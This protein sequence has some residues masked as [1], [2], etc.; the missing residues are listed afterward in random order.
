MFNFY[1]VKQGS[2]DSWFWNG[3]SKC[4]SKYQLATYL[5]VI[6]VSR[7]YQF[8]N[9]EGDVS[10]TPYYDK[11]YECEKHYASKYRTIDGSCNNIHRPYWG[12]SNTCHIRLLPPDYSDGIQAFRMAKNGKPLP[13]PREVSNHAMNSKDY[14][15]YYTSL[16][17]SWGQ[18]VAHDIMNTGK[19]KQSPANQ[20]QVD[21]C[22]KPD[23]KCAAIHIN[24][25]NDYISAKYKGRC[26]NFMRDHACPL[27]KLGNASFLGRVLIKTYNKIHLTQDLVST[28]T[29]KLPSS[30]DR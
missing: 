27:C 14:K 11:R 6:S 1:M 3:C 30:M 28:W 17:L 15:A 18:F 9:K 5:P 20:P 29:V 25:R 4:F 12:R 16:M 21:C 19:H 24:D 22:K 2:N 10:C 26:I 13:S 7:Q 8:L 23:S